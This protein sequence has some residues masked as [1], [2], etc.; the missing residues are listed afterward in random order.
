MV[1]RDQLERDLPANVSSDDIHLIAGVPRTGEVLCYM[2]LRAVSTPEATLRTRGRPLFPVEQAFGWGIYN[3]LPVLPDLP[4]A[5][6]VEISRF[7]KNQQ[8][9]A[10]ARGIARS[11]IEIVVALHH[12][13]CQPAHEITAAIGD[14]DQSVGKRYFEFF[15]LPAVVL[16]DAPPI[17]PEAGFLGWAVQSRHFGRSP[18]SSMTFPHRPG[19]WWKSNNRCG[20]RA[21]AA[22][23][24][25]SP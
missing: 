15:H 24:P 9:P 21:S 5:R 2:V 4:I 1:Y 25:C 18:S 8:I 10:R 17:A 3:G 19:G 11:P 13:L 7:V 22:F 12:V 14:I 20:C 16:H 6:I 23:D